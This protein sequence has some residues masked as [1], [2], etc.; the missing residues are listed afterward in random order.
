VATH[1]LQDLDI[2]PDWSYPTPLVFLDTA[3]KGWDDQRSEDDPSTQNPQ[4]AARTVEEVQKLLARG[5][6][7]AL[8]SVITPY[9]AQ[10]R[11]IQSLLG[12]SDVHVGTI[13]AFQGQENEA[14]V[15]DLVRSNPA[16]DLGFLKDYRRMNVA[17]TRAKRFL[18]VI[19]DSATIGTDSFYATFLETVE[20]HGTWAS[21]WA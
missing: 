7:P 17:L 14:V 5:L 12:D 9:E 19:G 2:E 1:T 15:V 10:R 11:T 8:I 20:A 4:Q 18:L 6:E 16:G 3:G 13:D 21:A